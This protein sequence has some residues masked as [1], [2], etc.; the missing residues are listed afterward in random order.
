[1]VFRKASIYGWS[2]KSVK[3]YKQRD[4]FM[5][6]IQTHTHESWLCNRAVVCVNRAL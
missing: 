2:A 4:F 5:I 1:L 3:N 6:V